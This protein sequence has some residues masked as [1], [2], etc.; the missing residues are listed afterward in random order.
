MGSLTPYQITEMNP[1]VGEMQMKRNVQ[2]PRRRGGEE[3]EE[4]E[5][6]E[7]KGQESWGEEEEGEEPALQ[8]KRVGEK[9]RGS[10]SE[11]QRGA[12][13]EMRGS[14]EGTGGGGS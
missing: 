1:P 6:V 7:R 5:E 10:V 12:L 13:G 8:D 11:W 4:E 2:I 14:D 9:K 3:R